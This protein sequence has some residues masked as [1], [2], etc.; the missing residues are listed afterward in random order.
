MP[1]NGQYNGTLRERLM[2]F[3]Q[4]VANLHNVLAEGH[5]SNVPFQRMVW[6]LL[7][8][9]RPFMFLN[10]A[11]EDNLLSSDVLKYRTGDDARDRRR[12]RLV[13]QLYLSVVRIGVTVPAAVLH[14]CLTLLSIAPK[15]GNPSAEAASHTQRY[16]KG[17]RFCF[18]ALYASDPACLSQLLTLLLSRD[19]LPSFI[20]SSVHSLPNYGSCSIEVIP[21]KTSLA[22]LREIFSL[23]DSCILEL[24][25]VTIVADSQYEVFSAAYAFAA[26]F[27][28]QPLSYTTPYRI[29]EVSTLVELSCGLLTVNVLTSDDSNDSH[30][31]KRARREGGPECDGVSET[32]RV[33]NQAGFLLAALAHGG[34]LVH[35]RHGPLIVAAL[36]NRWDRDRLNCCKETWERH[37]LQWIASCDPVELWLRVIFDN[38]Q[39]L[40]CLLRTVVVVLRA[41]LAREPAPSVGSHHDDGHHEGRTEV[42]VSI[43]RILKRSYDLQGSTRACEVM[44]RVFGRVRLDA[45]L[46]ALLSLRL[47]DH[48]WRGLFDSSE[49]HFPVPLLLSMFPPA[50]MQPIL[51]D[52]VERA[53]SALS[54]SAAF[55][56]EATVTAIFAI[57][58]SNSHERQLGCSKI[59]TDT[60]YELTKDPNADLQHIMESFALLMHHCDTDVSRWGVFLRGVDDFIVAN[61][62]AVNRVPPTLGA[63]LVFVGCSRL[64]VPAADSDTAVYMSIKRATCSNMKTADDV[65]FRCYRLSGF[66]G[67]LRI[68]LSNFLHEIRSMHGKE[69]EEMSTSRSTLSTSLC[70]HLKRL[71]ALLRES[72][73]LLTAVHHVTQM[74]SDANRF[75]SLACFVEP[76]A[77]LFQELSQMQLFLLDA[78]RLSVSVER[79]SGVPDIMV[80][81]SDVLECMVDVDQS[82]GDELNIDSTGDYATQDTVKVLRELH[83]EVPSALRFY[84]RLRSNKDL[85]DLPRVLSN[86]MKFLCMSVALAKSPSADVVCFLASELPNHE[87]VSVTCGFGSLALYHIIREESTTRS[88][89]ESWWKTVASRWLAWE[90]GSKEQLLRKLNLVRFAF[91]K[92]WSENIA[93][94]SKVEQDGS[95]FTDELSASDVNPPQW[96]MEGLTFIRDMYALWK[97]EAVPLD[98][99]SSAVEVAHAIMCGI[100]WSVAD[101]CRHELQ[102]VGS[103][104]FMV[105]CDMFDVDMSELILQTLDVLLAPCVLRSVGQ[106]AEN[107]SLQSVVEELRQQTSIPGGGYGPLMAHILYTNAGLP[108]TSKVTLL[109]EMAAVVGTQLSETSSCMSAAIASVVLNIISLESDAQLRAFEA[110]RGLPNRDPISMD[111]V[112]F[113]IFSMSL[114]QVTALCDCLP[115]NDAIQA[116]LQSPVSASTASTILVRSVF[117]VMDSISG[118]LGMSQQVSGSSFSQRGVTSSTTKRRWLLGLASFIRFLGAHSTLIAAKLPAMLEMCS[119]T[120]CLLDSVCLVLH[121]L[122]ANCAPEYL[123]EHAA[124]L[125]VEL[126]S[127]DIYNHLRHGALTVAQSAMKRLYALTS[128]DPLWQSYYVVMRGVSTLIP[129]VNP[130]SKFDKAESPVVS[131]E[132]CLSWSPAKAHVE[133]LSHDAAR[134]VVTGFLSVMQSSSVKCKALCV[135]ALYQ[136][137]KN[138]DVATRLSTT[139]AAEVSAEVIPTLLRCARELRDDDV[140]Y[141]FLCVGAIGAIAPPPV[142]F[143]GRAKS[144]NDI[145]PSNHG[146]LGSSAQHVLRLDTVLQWRQFVLTLLE[147]YCP[148]ALTNTADSMMHDRA[149]YAVQ[150]LLRVCTKIE[151]KANCDAIPLQDEDVLHVD[152]L[153]RYNWWRCL[154]GVSKNMLSGFTTTHYTTYIVQE[155]E[156]VIPAYRPGMGYGKW[157]FTLFCNLA[158]RCV[159]PFG[160]IIPLL[161]NVAKRDTALLLFLIPHIVVHLIEVAPVSDLAV[162]FLCVTQASGR[163]AESTQWHD[164]TQPRRPSLVGEHIQFTLHL[165]EDVNHL[166]WCLLRVSCKLDTINMENSGET[167]YRLAECCEAFLKEFSASCRPLAAMSIGS[168]LGALRSIESQRLLSNAA[169]VIQELPL[170]RIFAALDDRDSA[171]SI[172]CL[173][174]GLQPKD[175]AFSHENT[176]DWKLA[177]QN[178]E[179]VL[180][181]DPGSIPHQLT[182]LRCMKQLGQLHTMSRCAEALLAESRNASIDDCSYSTLQNYANEAAWRLGTWSK[183]TPG[184]SLPVSIAAPVVELL[185]LIHGNSTSGTQNVIAA[186]AQERRKLTS[187]IR[188][189]CREGYSQGYPFVTTL[190]AL[191]DIELTAEVLWKARRNSLS[192]ISTSVG[193]ST[194]KVSTL[195]E[196]AE[197]LSARMSYLDYSLEVREPILSLHRSIFRA[198][199]LKR[200]VSN[201]W[202]EHALLLQNS[203]FLEAALNAARQSELDKADDVH[204]EYYTLAAHLLHDMNCPM[205]AIEFA[206]EHVTN[207]KLSSGVRGKLQILHTNWVMEIGSR[208][209]KEVIDSYKI[210]LSMD[211]SEDAHH[212][213]A[214]FYDKLYAMNSKQVEPSK[215]DIPSKDRVAGKSIEELLQAVTAYGLH[216]VEHYGKALLKGVRTVSVSLPRMFTLWLDTAAV[217]LE[218]SSSDSASSANAGRLLKQLNALIETL[219]LSVEVSQRVPPKVVMTALPQLLSRLGHNSAHVVSIVSRIVVHLMG[220]FPQQCLWLVMPIAFS[221]Q[222]ARMMVVKQ[223]IISAFTQQKSDKSAHLAN[224]FSI[225]KALIELCK[226]PASEFDNNA[227]LTKKPFIEKVDRILPEANF[228]LPTMRNLSGNILAEDDQQVYPSGPTFHRFSDR[229]QV[230]NSLQSPKRIWVHTSEGTTVSFLCKDKDEPRKDIRM[231]EVASLMNT[232]FLSDAEA[233]RKHFCLRRYSIAALTDDCAIIE[234]VDDSVP[235]RVVVN[236]CYLL[237][238][239]GV[240]TSQVKAWHAKVKQKS[241]TNMELF[242]KYILPASPPVLHQWFDM[243]FTNNQE[244]YQARTLFTQSTA[245]WSIAGHIVGLGDRHCENLMMDGRSGELMHVDFACMFDKGETLEVP[246]VVRFRLTPNIIDGMGILG[247]DG[248]FRANCEVALR[249]QQKNKNAVMSIVETLLHDPLVEWISSSSRRSPVVPAKLIDRVSRRL[250][251]FLDLYSVPREQDTLALNIQGQVSRLISHSSAIENLS[252]MYI[253]WMAWI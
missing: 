2:A 90:T 193:E 149:A 44:S 150:E 186:A 65:I 122:V 3:G 19:G 177:L 106:A 209:P 109:A 152:E 98:V 20:P 72:L 22:E 227:K 77:A 205:Q 99:K 62:S 158:P 253:W 233:R 203:G 117:D 208:T 40:E 164:A 80:S 49:C 71:S 176:G 7:L 153:Q 28:D 202:I 157:L 191:A 248:P 119:S 17:V 163:D 84:D 195:K 59:T 249:C 58:S 156:P 50:L 73:S 220:F 34:H 167:C 102:M 213:L 38:D 92:G 242:T 8:E 145:R 26:I 212:H 54:V 251:G 239:T 124:S 30:I 211:S 16:M 228:I 171:R 189:A 23:A 162:E 237:S 112:S 79:H 68:R 45:H 11:Q 201:T 140:Q 159:G 231:M 245:L 116:A 82:E 241:I 121:D 144:S 81:R 199:K 151:R 5:R 36:A 210:A 204:P 125:A 9:L 194:W 146:V 25:R 147:V 225:F 57:L 75:P 107:P 128:N 252:E 238:N 27:T 4:R 222:E 48:D 118:R 244:W 218:I 66:S 240:R 154:S 110:N 47:P 166:R 138:A 226:C 104:F 86:V 161:R 108:I 113:S 136:Y 132:S 37:L 88:P 174:R 67:A 21:T 139:R 94:Q 101:L 215:R 85:R 137:L 89:L 10:S 169:A 69:L 216:A 188:T 142:K 148:R 247:V 78:C 83:D 230:M 133:G 155:T 96:G 229:V 160:D 76:A 180:Q 196:L 12:V 172:H 123:T 31:R 182:S 15:L 236:N 53:R 74:L 250:D 217:L 221:K 120:P 14:G 105:L 111:D 41:T 87:D 63:L 18:D 55:F 115:T 165:L 33:H 200:E 184:E 131:A 219:I 179:L 170:Q 56:V 100:N 192:T 91:S 64:P 127:L 198:V 93:Y 24:F 235:I 234:W 207:A 95:A 197:T 103:P 60:I 52:A 51:K 114:R 97:C 70:T 206:Q 141:A 185:H 13:T 187:I 181:H 39:I 61:R 190:H 214:L 224:A 173:S 168:N 126:L 246:E 1:F 183:V 29:S 6:G 35:H 32:S 178:C 143:D 223:S 43:V 130:A 232:F 46:D 134:A 129:D 42:A 135:R 175:A 243:M